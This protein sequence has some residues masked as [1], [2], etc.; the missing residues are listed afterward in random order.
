MCEESYGFPMA[1][2]AP[3]VDIIAVTAAPRKRPVIATMENVPRMMRK[4]DCACAR[5]KNNRLPSP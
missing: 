1:K 3:S 2:T 4:A 5:G